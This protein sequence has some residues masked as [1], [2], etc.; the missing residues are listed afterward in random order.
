MGKSCV[1]QRDQAARCIRKSECYKK[2]KSIKECMEKNEAP[3]CEGFLNAFY[4]C[5]RSQLDMRS[6]IRGPK[7]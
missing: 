7:L 4:L 6:R 2:G 1:D 5:K 3:E